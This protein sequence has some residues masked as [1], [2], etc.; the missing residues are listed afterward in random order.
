V[1]KRQLGKVLGRILG[2][3]PGGG[4]ED[5]IR[6]SAVAASLREAREGLDMDLKAAAKAIGVPQYRLRYIEGCSIKNLRASDL[7]AYIEF[8][9]LSRWFARWSKANPK[10]AQRLAVESRTERKTRQMP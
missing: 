4:I 7:R 2:E 8:L 9:G 10:L 5:S 6:F 1:L 3:I